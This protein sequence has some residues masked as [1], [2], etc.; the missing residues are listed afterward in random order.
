MPFP[1]GV[2]SA[3][4]ATAAYHFD[5]FLAYKMSDSVQPQWQG[6]YA[7][8]IQCAKGV[9]NLFALAQTILGN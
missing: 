1:F 4:K 9:T 2:P 3:Q 6:D 5:D 8:Y 7:N